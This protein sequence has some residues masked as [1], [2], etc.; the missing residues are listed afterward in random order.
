MPKSG[1]IRLRS[2]SRGTISPAKILVIAEGQ[3]GDL[4]VLTPA[5]RAVKTSFPHAF[6]AVLIVQRRRYAGGAAT[7]E[8]W[9]L[10]RGSHEGTAA[11]LGENRY[12]DEV[13]EVDRGTLR[14]LHGLARIR[15]EAGIVRFLRAQ[16]F[17]AVVGAFPEDRFVLWAWV[18]GAG[19]RVGQRQQKLFP[20]LTHSPDIR[21]EEKGVLRYYCD[22][23]A[24]LGASA[25]SYATEYRI[26]GAAQRWAEEF[27]RQSRLEGASGLVAVHPG[28]SGP[29]RVW[30][31]ERFAALIDGLQREGKASVLLCGT[32]YD[33]AAVNEVR[34]HLRT[35]VQEINF[36]ES[37]ARFAAVLARCRCCISNDSGPRHLAVAVGTPTLA[38]M[39]RFQDRSWKL[40]EDECRNV[41]LQGAQRCPACPEGICR[42][43]IPQG[44]SLG[45]FCLRMIPV[46]QAFAAAQHFIAGKSSCE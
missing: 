45:S 36:G 40:Y 39:P 20:L 27:L 2:E 34:R 22:L 30:P 19:T 35:P 46:Q 31:P 44:E 38:F 33:R 41:V 13:I 1:K 29:Y 25:E 14:T 18:S 9:V 12:V 24:E 28:A 37:V 23:V 7:R 42:D 6:L 3:L 5:L 4:L 17:D 21:K 26:P 10:R 11:V 16:K 15:A 32:D 8:S 43:A